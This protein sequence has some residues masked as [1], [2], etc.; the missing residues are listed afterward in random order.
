[1]RVRY[2]LAGLSVLSA[3]GATQAGATAGPAAWACADGA[4]AG[5]VVH[6]Y[7]HAAAEAGPEREPAGD[8]AL[9][10]GT[11]GYGFRHILSRHRGDWSHTGAGDWSTL[12]DRAVAAALGQPD[13][14]G[15]RESN[16][17]FCYSHAL[18][19][20]EVT[21]VVIRDSDGAI[22][23]AY[24]GNDQCAVDDKRD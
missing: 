13:R 8:T 9:L 20:G 5:T 19:D 7:T 10:C 21:T 4:P 16:H 2:V 18:P 24:P 6:R 15:S 11:A 12:A 23:T 3:C 17:T 22:I 1:M 14:V